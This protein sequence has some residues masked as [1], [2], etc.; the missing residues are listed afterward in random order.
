MSKWYWRDG[1]IAMEDD[2]SKI[3]SKDWLEEMGKIEEKLS[4]RDY[5]VVEQTKLKNGYF[6]STVWLGLDHAI[7]GDKPAI[8]ET[9]VFSDKGEIG[10]DEDMMRYS[11]EKEAIRGHKRM[12]AKWKKK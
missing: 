11:T 5:K 12:V 7:Y 1:T 3:G 6:V 2:I 4:D 10:E 9:M 8:F